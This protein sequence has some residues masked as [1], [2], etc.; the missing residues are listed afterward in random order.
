MRWFRRRIRREQDLQR[1]IASHLQAEADEQREQGV[2]E[3]EADYAARR[4]FGNT[5]L[6]QEDTRAVWGWGS[7]ERLVQDLRYALRLL[8]KSPAFTATAILSL[9]LGIGMNTAIFSLL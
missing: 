3:S 1:E 8:R 5:T 7:I 4:A 2:S 6:V 9:T